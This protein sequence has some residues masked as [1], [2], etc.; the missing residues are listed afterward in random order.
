MN[1]LVWMVV[2]AGL[3]LPAAVLAV[4]PVSWDGDSSPVLV[5]NAT[6]VTRSYAVI[7]T[8]NPRAKVD[9][10][11]RFTLPAGGMCR[12]DSGVYLT[13]QQQ[14]GAARFHLTRGRAAGYYPDSD[15][16]L[17]GV[18]QWGWYVE[19]VSEG[20]RGVMNGPVEVSYPST[21]ER[22][23][24]FV[25]PDRNVAGLTSCSAV[26]LDEC[27]GARWGSWKLALM[28]YGWQQYLYD[29]YE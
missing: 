13:P 19:D 10:S 12:I 15:R 28:V 22:S 24:F 27:A 8:A 20:P 6:D 7:S 2:A 1:K 5:V 26:G 21:P 4:E 16:S 18:T 9:I 3:P 25:I 17:R 23:Y 14:P 29:E 11:R